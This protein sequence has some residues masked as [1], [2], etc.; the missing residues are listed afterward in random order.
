MMK[1]PHTDKVNDGESARRR[2]LKWKA[3]ELAWLL[4]WFS[5]CLYMEW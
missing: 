3:E 4:D 1:L 2:G 5:D